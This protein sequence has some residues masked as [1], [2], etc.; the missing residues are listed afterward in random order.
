MWAN[1]GTMSPNVR[2]LS[3]GMHSA[4]YRYGEWADQPPASS[5][6]TEFCCIPT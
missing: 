2:W 1:N 4:A 3:T 6:V 5:A